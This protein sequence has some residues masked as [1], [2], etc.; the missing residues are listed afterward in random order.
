MLLKRGNNDISWVIGVAKLCI[1]SSVNKV[2]MELLIRFELT[3][4]DYT[5]YNLE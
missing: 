1:G 3:V 4:S 2:I 5:L